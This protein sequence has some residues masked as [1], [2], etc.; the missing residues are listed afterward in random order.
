[1]ISRVYP[2]K[3][4]ETTIIISIYVLVLFSLGILL[5]EVRRHQR[6]PL[7]QIAYGILRNPFIVAI[8]LGVL[9]FALGWKVPV[10]VHAALDMIAQ[11]A[12]PVVLVSL[13]VF[14]ARKIPL[15]SIWK[16]ALAVSA[17]RLFIVPALFY[18]VAWRLNSIELYEVTVLEAA[19]PLAVTPFA[20]S[21]MYPLDRSLTVTVIFISSIASLV[22]LPL[23]VMWMAV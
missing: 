5:L 16:P 13:G 19:M 3:G 21:S 22:T 17:V 12:S 8:V 4:P 10:A 1:L 9:V 2:G 18:V 23:W 20:L 7:L 15:R 6:E 14:L 11:S